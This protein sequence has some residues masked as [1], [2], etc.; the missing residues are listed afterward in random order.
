VNIRVQK[1]ISYTIKL[2]GMQVFGYT[3]KLK[4][5]AHGAKRLAK[6]YFQLR[7]NYYIGNFC[8]WL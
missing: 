3:P 8:G 6:F 2:M 7:P 4:H 1:G 5:Y